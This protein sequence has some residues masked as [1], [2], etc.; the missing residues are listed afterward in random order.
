[1][2]HALTIKSDEDL[3][4]FL[5]NIDNLNYLES[6]PLELGDTIIKLKLEGENFESSLPGSLILGLAKYQEKIYTTYLASK[7]GVGTRH[8]ITPEEAKLLEIKVIVKP[9]STEVWIELI[10][11]AW[12]IIGQ[13]MSPDQISSTFIKIAVIVAVAYCL[14]GIASVTIK[15]ILKTKRRE[16]ANKKALSRDEVEKKK[17]EFLESSVNAAIEGIKAVCLGIVQAGPSR[18]EIN[19]KTVST[20]DIKSAIVGLEPKKLE[21]K[22][23]ESIIT[24]TYLIQ[25]VTLDFKKDSASVDVLD[26]VSGDPIHGLIVKHKHLSDGSYNKILNAAQEKQNIKLQ[27]RI[28]TRNDRIHKAVLDKILDITN[29]RG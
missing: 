17:L 5:E 1:M 12:E 16:F 8:K 26:S 10:D 9:G 25:R 3:V 21:V 29:N 28:T 22:E 27:I 13:K 7:Y 4:I 19:G 20:A 23:E 2:G 18:I 15:E 11:K 24:G 14:K 6:N